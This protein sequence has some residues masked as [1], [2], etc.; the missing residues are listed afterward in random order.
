MQIRTDDD[1]I[2]AGAPHFLFVD[3]LSELCPIGK[4]CIFVEGNTKIDIENYRIEHQH[5]EHTATVHLPSQIVD[6]KNIYC[7]SAL[8]RNV[9]SQ[10][11]KL[12]SL[13]QWLLQPAKPE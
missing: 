1:V 4:K 11:L 10:S 7:L 2:F 8:K 6:L 13:A 3:W 5:I 9:A 12:F